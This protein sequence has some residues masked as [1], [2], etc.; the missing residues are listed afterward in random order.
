[1]IDKRQLR[2]MI[3]AERAGEDESVRSERAQHMSDHAAVLRPSAEPAVAAFQP[4]NG[5]P[6][7][8]PLLVELGLPVLVPRLVDG[9]TLEWVQVDSRDVAGPRQGIPRPDGPSVAV[10]AE[11][12]ARV[13]TILVP[14]LAVDP[15]SG[16][17]LGYGSGYYDRLLA[18]LPS[19][20]RVVA[21]CRACDL[22]ELP[23]EP[24][25]VPVAE[26]LTEHGLEVVG[27]A[28][29]PGARTA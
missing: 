8:G 13:G 3:R 16:V 25:D 2:R 24:H 1:M 11:V 18:G 20:V 5:E 23:S 12:A 15:R 6:E 17:R 22:M 4:T 10:G 21:V 7:I 29:G 28:P 14:A 26:V 19:H 9:E 27:G